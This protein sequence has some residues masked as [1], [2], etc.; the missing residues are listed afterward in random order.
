ML[1]SATEYWM[2]SFSYSSNFNE[3]ME[4][5]QASA[6]RWNSQLVPREWERE[7][8]GEREETKKDHF[9][10]EEKTSGKCNM[11]CLCEMYVVLNSMASNLIIVSSYKWSIVVTCLDIIMKYAILM[12]TRNREFC[13]SLKCYATYAISWRLWSIAIKECMTTIARFPICW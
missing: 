2:T 7:G 1:I 10:Y 4:K 11:N 12:T 6:P 3:Q 5:I 9:E 13:A 8:E